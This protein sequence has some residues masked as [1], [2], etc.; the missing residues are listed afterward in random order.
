MLQSVVSAVLCCK[1]LQYHFE[2]TSMFTCVAETDAEHIA[3]H[4]FA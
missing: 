3:G 2:L 4:E 1:V